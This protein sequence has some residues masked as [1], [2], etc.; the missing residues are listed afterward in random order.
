MGT[1]SGQWNTTALQTKLA[2][3]RLNATLSGSGRG[4]TTDVS[5]RSVAIS[6]GSNLSTHRARRVPTSLTPSSPTLSSSP[7][8]I[9]IGATSN[10]PPPTHHYEQSPAPNEGIK[11]SSL[12]SIIGSIG[13][14]VGS[15]FGSGSSGTAVGPAA[16]SGGSSL[17]GTAVGAAGQ[18]VGGLLSP[19]SSAIVS[20]GSSLA[21]LPGRASSVGT[22]AL[23]LERP[24]RLAPMASK[25]IKSLVRLV[26]VGQASEIVGLPVEQVAMIA[27][28]SR[29]RRRGISA[30]DLATTK[31]V[32][33]RV[34]GIARDLQSI[35]PPARRSY[36]NRSIKQV[37]N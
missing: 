25:L 35:R 10:V 17:L 22:S 31:R 12:S 8:T 18:I 9:D 26:G 7:L 14:V 36:G 20:L 34:L 27:I 28:R 11:M 1:F 2:R 21:N 6:T 5:P 24:A 33:R 4:T 32:T 19:G 30:R 37:C 16:G 23:M 13:N 15:I 29:R 3:A